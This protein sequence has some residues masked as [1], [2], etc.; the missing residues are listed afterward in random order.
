MPLIKRDDGSTVVQRDW[1]PTLI[2]IGYTRP[3]P[4]SCRVIS[5]DMERLQSSLLK[6]FKPSF[7]NRLLTVLRIQRCYF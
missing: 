5:W 1:G 3:C 7:R 2:S 4:T 6:K